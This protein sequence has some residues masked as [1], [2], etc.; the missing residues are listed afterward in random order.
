MVVCE[1]RPEKD[2]PDHTRITIGGNRICFPVDVGTNTASLEL[3]K[4]LLNSVL[5]CS[6]ARFSSIDL[7]I[8]YLDTPMPDPEYIRIKIA[9][10]LAEFIEEYNLQGCN[11]D[12]WIYLKIRQGCYG[13]PQA[14]ILANNLLQSRL[15]AEGYYKVDSTPGLR[16]HKWR[17]IQF[18][19]IVDDFA[20]EYVGIEHFHHLCD[21]LKKFHGVQFNMAGNKFAGIDIKWDYATRRCHISMPGYIENLLIKFKHPHPTKPRLSPHKCLPI[22]YGAKAQLTPDADMSELLNEHRKS[23][24]QEIFGSLLYY[25]RAVNDK[26]LVAFSV[27]ADRQS[28][29]TVATKQA[30]H[31][32]LDYVATYPS[33]GIIY[34]ASDMVLC[35]I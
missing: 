28:C 17:P 8:F 7:K 13:L 27:I 4:L 23:R 29:A 18:C 3:I 16:H 33:D 2:D 12:R 32:L 14:G 31:L 20:V 30:V 26:L 34:Q 15:L 35:A 24:I 1:V 9:D 25:A 22:S 5:S 10:I 6:G 21:V 19:L 11:H